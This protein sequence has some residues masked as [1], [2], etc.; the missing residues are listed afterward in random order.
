M[1]D[2]PNIEE[3]KQQKLHKIILRV[4]SYLPTDILFDKIQYLSK[5]LSRDI[6]D[7]TKNFILRDGRQFILSSY[8]IDDYRNLKQL[9]F[10]LRT[11]SHFKVELSQMTDFSV[12]ALQNAFIICDEMNLDPHIELLTNFDTDDFVKFSIQNYVKRATITLIAEHVNME[13]NNS[14]FRANM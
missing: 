5:G 8:Q 14:L 13:V 3:R 9:P 2:N 10:A 11:C 12:L 4:F 1:N 7:A 6:K